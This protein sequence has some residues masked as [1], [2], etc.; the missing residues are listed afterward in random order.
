M[1]PVRL[2]DRVD[3]RDDEARDAQPQLS[4]ATATTAT[5]T[6]NDWRDEDSLNDARLK[7]VKFEIETKTTKK[8]F[9][10]VESVERSCVAFE[11]SSD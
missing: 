8:Q 10:F 4:S 5:A 11:L 9:L 3:D 7:S 1:P 2:R 6:V